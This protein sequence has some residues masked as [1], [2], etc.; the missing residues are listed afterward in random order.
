M[1]IKTTGNQVEGFL[2]SGEQVLQIFF[3]N[4]PISEDNPQ[5]GIQVEAL[6]EIAI[7]RLQALNR[8]MSCHENSHAIDA[9]RTAGAW[10][11]SRTLRRIAQK[12]EGTDKPH[13]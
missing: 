8:Y 10:L 2:D 13:E 9:L 11:D 6:I 7:D 1:V 4:K 12:V 3:Q 5:N